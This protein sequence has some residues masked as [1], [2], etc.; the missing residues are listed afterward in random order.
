MAMTTP[1]RF[2][3]GLALLLVFVAALNAQAPASRLVHDTV[4]DG[5]RGKQVRRHAESVGA[6]LSAAELRVQP[7][8]RYPVVY[9]LHGFTASE[10]S[11]ARGYAGFDIGRSTDSL[12]A[13]GAVRE[14]II[15]M[16]NALNRLRG[17]ST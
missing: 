13:A 1:F 2:R 16:P 4:H 11:W 9:L 17:T 3:S 5:A 12:V 6:C 7:D 8:Q 14:M 15:V 10:V